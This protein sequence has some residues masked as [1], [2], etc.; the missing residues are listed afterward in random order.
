MGDLFGDE[1]WVGV[2]FP[3]YQLEME[4]ELACRTSYILL[5]LPEQTNTD[6]QAR[7]NHEAWL[8]NDSRR[9]VTESQATVSPLKYFP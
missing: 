3:L 9:V 4:Q 2:W 6:T 8:Q 7:A 5:E 1:P